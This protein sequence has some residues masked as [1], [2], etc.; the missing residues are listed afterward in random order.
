MEQVNGLW[1]NKL[2]GSFQEGDAK[3]TRFFVEGKVEIKELGGHLRAYFKDVKLTVRVNTDK[4]AEEDEEKEKGSDD[5]DTSSDEEDAD[6]KKKDVKAEED[7]YIPKLSVYMTTKKPKKR[8]VDAHKS[9]TK[10]KMA[11]LM[12]GVFGKLDE[13]VE[14]DTPLVD[15]SDV[16]NYKG[17]VVIKMPSDDP[18]TE[19]PIIYGYVR[20]Q[21]TRSIKVKSIDALHLSDLSDMLVKLNNRAAIL[22]DSMTLGPN[23]KK[24]LKPLHVYSSIS[25]KAWAHLAKQEEELADFEEVLKMLD[26]LDLFMLNIQAQRIFDAVDLKKYGKISISDFEN[27]LIAKEIL[28]PLSKE[29]KALDVYDSLKA[30]PVNPDK[31]LEKEKELE[32]TKTNPSFILYSRKKHHGLDYPSFIEAVQILGFKPDEELEDPNEPI[33]DAFC[34]GGGIKEKDI[35]TKYLTIQEFRK[36]WLKIA[37]VSAEMEK[38][39]LKPEGGLFAESRNRERLSQSI[40]ET[41]NTYLKNLANVND[42]VMNLKADHRRRR[43]EHRR[44]KEA[45]REKLLHEANKFMAERA[46]EKRLQLKREQEEKSK[47]RMEDKILRNKLQQRQQ[48]NLE[49]KR[50]EI[51]KSMNEATRL[52]LHEIKA[53]GLDRLD[54]SV[55]NLREIP[56]YLYDNNDAQMKLSY[57]VTADM[58]HNVLDHLPDEKFLYWLTETRK[59]KLSQNRLK[60]LPEELGDLGKVEILE[61]ESNRLEILPMSFGQLRSLQRLDIS[62]NQLRSLPDNIGLCAALKYLNVHSNLL[63]SLPSSLGDCFQ[64]EYLDCSRNEI[65]E[66]PEDMEHLVSLT[67]LDLSSNQIGHLPHHIGNCKALQYLDMSCNVLASIPESFSMLS[68]LEYCNLENNAIIAASHCFGEVRNIKYLNLRRNQIRFFTSDFGSM[69]NLTKLD[70]SLNHLEFLPIEIG[71]MA[72]LETLKLDRNALT[73]IPPELGSCLGLQNL[74]ISYN[75]ITGCLPETLSL[76]RGITELNISFN[77]IDELPRSIVAFREVSNMISIWKFLYCW[78]LMTSC[79]AIYPI[80][81]ELQRTAMYVAK[82]ARYNRH[83]RSSRSYR[84]AK[85]SIYNISYWTSYYEEA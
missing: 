72:D 39:N 40:N 51:A 43:D 12:D 62:N 48:E 70:I 9:G 26:F 46:K 32:K 50:Q 24:A 5:S 36:A 3:S 49:M 69:I 11:G 82:L 1:A 84:L 73:T 29:V 77:K 2:S 76:I 17:L 16:S 45:Q 53:Q 27:F 64:L 74:N 18:P 37:D 56:M 66:L 38:R 13:A 57:V 42:F 20:L 6:K 61:L 71:L 22:R 80:V 58:S 14:Y 63:N 67:H 30:E 41:E 7:L 44:Q 28:T 25:S 65:R 35:D 83:I 10:V 15:I 79:N 52:K 34:F 55:K 59:L 54:I 85:Q 31:V 47:K 75:A 68:M 78:Y 21:S 23:V 19:E 60:H 33:K 8:M 4:K 81:G